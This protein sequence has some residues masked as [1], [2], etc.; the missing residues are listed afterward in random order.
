MAAAR[1]RHSRARDGDVVRRT[2]VPD[3]AASIELSACSATWGAYER[4]TTTTFSVKAALFEYPRMGVSARA[5][6]G[7][8]ETPLTSRLRPFA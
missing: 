7:S 5:R 4:A 2:G 8:S 1:R 3:D 6:P